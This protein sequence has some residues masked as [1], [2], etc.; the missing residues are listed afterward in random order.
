M[1]GKASTFDSDEG[2]YYCEVTGDQC[3][4]YI[5]NSKACAEKYGEGPDAV[6]STE[7]EE[8]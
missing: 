2:R 5:P 6:D 1:A 3:M 4:F 7:E 8:E